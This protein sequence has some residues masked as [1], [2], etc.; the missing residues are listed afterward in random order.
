[1]NKFSLVSGGGFRHPGNILFYRQSFPDLVVLRH[2][3]RD[4]GMES[5]VE[6]FFPLVNSLRSFQTL[7]ATSRLTLSF[8]SFGFY[9]AY[10][11][12]ESC[13]MNAKV[14]AWATSELVSVSL[15]FCWSVGLT[16]GEGHL[17]HPNA[18][19]RLLRLE[20][21]SGL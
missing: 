5:R 19:V 2:F 12:G 1:M 16:T 9:R 13:P 3:G 14:L 17:L 21:R 8:S 11:R 7:L 18:N 15:V 4:L 10:I 20:C 6:T